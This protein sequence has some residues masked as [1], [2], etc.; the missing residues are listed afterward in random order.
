MT[1][2]A[3]LVSDPAPA[4]GEYFCSNPYC[5][6][7]L[8]DEPYVYFAATAL[9]CRAA[10]ER[11]GWRFDPYTKTAKCPA[12]SGARRQSLIRRLLRLPMDA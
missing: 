11:D 4:M 2:R 3:S 7:G 9:E 10:A 6:R 12:D 8:S 1:Y 5:P